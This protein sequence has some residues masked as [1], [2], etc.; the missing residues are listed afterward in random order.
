MPWDL[1]N[2]DIPVKKPKEVTELETMGKTNRDS[3][4]PREM[5]EKVE[6]AALAVAKSY[7][8]LPGADYEGCIGVV[9]V[10]LTVTGSALG[11]KFGAHM[12]SL[13]VSEAELACKLVYDVEE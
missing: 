1:D 2:P 10:A 7:K 3:M 11:G 4:P 13:S 6:D 9:T 12:V 5:D 8:K